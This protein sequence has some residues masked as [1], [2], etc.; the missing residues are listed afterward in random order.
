MLF[1]SAAFLCF[2]FSPVQS[3]RQLLVRMTTD[4]GYFWQVTTYTTATPTTVTST[5]VESFSYPVTITDSTTVFTTE[6]STRETTLTTSYSYP[7][8]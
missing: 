1:G 3:R 6:Y 8:T 2:G 5:T 4:H 7:V